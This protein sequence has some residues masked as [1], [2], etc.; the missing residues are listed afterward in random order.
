MAYMYKG[1]KLQYAFTLKMV[2]KYHKKTFLLKGKTLQRTF[3]L[4]TTGRHSL[5]SKHYKS[6]VL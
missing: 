5:S 3:A 4:L 6:L 2:N 1:K